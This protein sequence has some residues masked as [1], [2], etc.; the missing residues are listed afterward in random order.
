M[1]IIALNV[2]ISII[3]KDGKGMTYKLVP[4]E[5]RKFTKEEILVCANFANKMIGNHN[6]AMILEREIYMAIS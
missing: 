5:I 4:C 3:I 2:I 6:V 1:L